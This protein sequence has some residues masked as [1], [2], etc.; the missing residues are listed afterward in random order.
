M[1][2]VDCAP[3]I[4]ILIFKHPYFYIK[5]VKRGIKLIRDFFLRPYKGAGT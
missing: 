5:A 4:Y 2:F 3:C 1:T